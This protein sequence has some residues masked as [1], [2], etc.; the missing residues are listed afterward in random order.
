MLYCTLIAVVVAIVIHAEIGGVGAVSDWAYGA[1]ATQ[2]SHRVF[3][4]F[5]HTIDAAAGDDLAD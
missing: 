5:G 3:N 1:S 2:G 4:R